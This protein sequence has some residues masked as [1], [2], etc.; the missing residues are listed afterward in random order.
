MQ[1]D[2]VKITT[3]NQVKSRRQKS[4]NIDVLH[5]KVI[6]TTEPVVVRQTY[7]TLFKSLLH[8]LISHRITVHYIHERRWESDIYMYKQDYW[9]YNRT[10]GHTCH[11]QTFS[12]HLWLTLVVWVTRA[13]TNKW[14]I[15]PAL[16]QWHLVTINPL[17]LTQNDCVWALQ[18]PTWCRVENQWAVAMSCLRK[19][20]HWY[21]W[22]WAW[23]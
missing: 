11:I 19:K 21:S 10:F 12:F 2:K 4:F 13:V 17:Q 14:I 20:T 7:Q 15:A 6:C 18:M 9:F 1:H 23:C 16:R 3:I 5:I 8:F 22:K